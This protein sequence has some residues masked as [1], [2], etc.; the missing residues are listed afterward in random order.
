MITGAGSSI[1][2]RRTRVWHTLH[3]WKTEPSLEGAKEI[4][5]V[6]EAALS[7]GRL[8]LG[9]NFHAIDSHVV[10]SRTM[11]DP[12]GETSHGVVTIEVLAEEV[13]P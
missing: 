3:V 2:R 7:A 11:R 6:V 10:S 1:L 5:G 4:C 12:D 9:P 8:D 13:T